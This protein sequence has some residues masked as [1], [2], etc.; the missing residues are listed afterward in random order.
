[1][2]TS[3]ASNEP[4]PSTSS[5]C[6]QQPGQYFY[7]VKWIN[8]SSETSE[9]V[10][11]ITQNANGPCPLIAIMNVLLLRGK[12]KL[13]P[14]TD[15]VSSEQLMELLGD[16]VLSGSAKDDASEEERLNYEQ[17]VHD[18]IAIF[19]K[20][21][22]GLDVNVKFSGVKD[23]EYTPE[24]IVFDLLGIDLYHGWLIDPQQDELVRATAGLGYN[25]LVEK[26]IKQKSSTD[27]ASVSE[28]L[29]AEQFLERS[30]SQLTYYGLVELGSR[31]RDGEL[32]VL[33]R[34]NH[35]STLCKQKGH[36]YQLVTDQGFLNESDVVW[37]S[38]ENVEGDCRFVDADFCPMRRVV[39]DA[40]TVAGTAPRPL[41]AGC[42]E[43]AQE[44]L[45]EPVPANQLDNDYLLAL[46]LQEE[47]KGSSASEATGS[48]ATT[49]T[50]MQGTA[51]LSDLELAKQLQEE[52]D[53]RA[54]AAM[55]A[56]SAGAT[57][58][59]SGSARRQA[60]ASSNHSAP[61]VADQK[62]PSKDKCTL[63]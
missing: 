3:A 37:Q 58:V 23:F 41:S 12:S 53:S 8:W 59:S 30:A 9:P 57:T 11:V 15:V 10:P 5:G 44:H 1:M 61:Q 25:Q 40:R 54:A 27:E 29:V 14:G 24:C 6:G 47:S 51:A 39:D 63:L 55:A 28:A 31:L 16:L 21:Q 48:A 36:L 22:T 52:E 4:Q 60:A 2:E 32:C 56:D 26:I 13:N 18:G 17:N 20:L 42:Q 7:Q 46:S 45:Q 49:A 33:F 35:F 38:L 50:G 62:K 43:G 34:N 19:H